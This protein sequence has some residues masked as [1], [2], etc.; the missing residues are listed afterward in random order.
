MTLQ[1]KPFENI[2]GKGENVSKMFSTQSK[3]YFIIGSTF[4]LLS[5][6]ALTLYHTITT[7]D[8]QEAL[9]NTNFNFSVTFIFSSANAFNLN[10]YKNLVVVW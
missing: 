10:Q 5:R 8:D 1:K 3:K 6:N 7:I 9:L 2:V 4:K